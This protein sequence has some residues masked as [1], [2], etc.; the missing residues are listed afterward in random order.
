MAVCPTGTLTEGEKGYRVQVA[1]KLGRHPKLAKE[2]PGIFDEKTVLHIIKDCI[3]FYKK[4]S[5]HGE[6]FAEIFT[7]SDFL[8]LAEQYNK[9]DH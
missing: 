3:D 2:L 6:R 5:L 7:D 4:N 1:G 9:G 8:K